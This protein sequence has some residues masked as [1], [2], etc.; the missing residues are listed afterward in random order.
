LSYTFGSLVSGRVVRKMGV[1]NVTVFF[2]FLA[3]VLLSIFTV[4]PYLWLAL[5]AYFLGPFCFGVSFP[6]N[7]TLLLGQ[8]SEYHGTLMA[9]NS[10][11]NSVGS[12]IGAGVGGFIV[13]SWGYVVLGGVLGFF[14]VLASFIIYLLVTE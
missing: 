1:K 8:D 6:A 10:A 5:G 14:G 4:S 3:G 9:F 7:M 11:S 2:L 12:A 13:L